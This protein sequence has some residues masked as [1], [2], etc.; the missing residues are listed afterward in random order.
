[1][2]GQSDGSIDLSSFFDLTSIHELAH[3]FQFQASVQFPRLWLDEFFANL[4]LH[5]YVASQ[6]PDLLPVLETFPRLMLQAGAARFQYHSLADFERLYSDVGD[7]NYG[8]Y[9]CQLEVAAKAVYDSGGVA[10]LQRL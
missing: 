2:Y 6:Q 10:A 5:A 4:S 7:A 1:V 8:W 3:L 9:Q